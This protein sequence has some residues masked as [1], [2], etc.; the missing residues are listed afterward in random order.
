MV[1]LDTCLQAGGAREKSGLISILSSP[2]RR[3]MIQDEVE[4]VGEGVQGSARSK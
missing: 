3:K 1:N 2:N 4:Q